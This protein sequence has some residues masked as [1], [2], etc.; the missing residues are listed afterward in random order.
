MDKCVQASVYTCGSFKYCLEDFW[1]CGS[2]NV[3][4]KAVEAQCFLCEARY[5]FTCFSLECSGVP[6]TKE[7]KGAFCTQCRA[8]VRDSLDYI[9]EPFAA[10]ASVIIDS[11]RFVDP[12]FRDLSDPPSLPRN[13]LPPPL[14]LALP[15]DMHAEL[16][17]CL[18][19]MEHRIKDLKTRAERARMRKVQ[20]RLDGLR[21]LMIKQLKDIVHRMAEP[22]TLSYTSIGR[23][24]R[25]CVSS[26]SRTRMLSWILLKTCP[27]SS[28]GH[29][30]T[31]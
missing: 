6:L 18:R 12:P 17:I 24:C 9:L 15:P 20:D 8:T 3:K 25:T 19:L 30:L 28:V 23:G 2:C 21:G 11:P 4:F 31:N 10:A 13:E 27:S 1:D 22:D 16:T 29:A 7:N 14:D 26:I 5:C